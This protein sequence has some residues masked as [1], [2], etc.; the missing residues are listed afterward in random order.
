MKSSIP[1]TIT[2]SK[3][4]RESWKRGVIH[5]KW[6]RLYPSI[7][8]SDDLRLA[9]AQYLYGNHYSEWV[10]AIALLKRFGWMS[11]IEKYEF[12]KH[13]R[14]QEILKKLGIEL[15]RYKHCQ[16]PDLLI[17]DTVGNWDF[18]EVK[19]E[20]DKLSVRQKKYFPLIEKKLKKRIKILQ[21]REI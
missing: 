9:H 10:V 7:F 3:K 4:D 16:Y 13:T 15:E 20:T 2:V 14:K 19:T 8:D 17:Y 21:L 5:E 11:L 18:V 1:G 12:K 6:A